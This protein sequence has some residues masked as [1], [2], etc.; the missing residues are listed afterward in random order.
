MAKN[1]EARVALEQATDPEWL[2]R[3][4]KSVAHLADAGAWLQRASSS[5]N[6]FAR[7]RDD[8]Y[9]AAER[10]HAG[11]LDDKVRGQFFA[12]LF[13]K[14]AEP[15]EWAWAQ[16]PQAAYRIS[17]LDSPFRAPTHAAVVTHWREEWFRLV[18]R[19]LAGHDPDPAWL[20][21]WGGHLSWDGIDESAQI[22]AAV[23]DRGGAAG[24]EVFEIL[25]ASAQG[26]HEIGVMGSHVVRAMLSTRRE[27]AWAFIERM[28]LAAQREE[29]L[30]RSILDFAPC[31]HPGALK[32]LLKVVLEENLVRFAST[33]SSL[34]R[35]FGFEWDSMSIGHARSIIERVLG[36]LDDPAAQAAGIKGK[37]AET[38]YLALWCRGHHD[39]PA[40]A[41]QAALLLKEKSAEKAWVGVHALSEFH[42]PESRLV[43]ARAI[44]HPDL[45]VAARAV[46]ALRDWTP[47][48]DLDLAD[49]AA[50]AER[51]LTTFEACERLLRRMGGKTVAIRPI[52][53]PW[54]ETTLLTDDVEGLM[55]S[56]ATTSETS[57]RLIPLLGR[58]SVHTR[59]SA[60]WKIAGREMHPHDAGPTTKPEPL[61]PAVRSTIIGLLKDPAKDVRAAAG[62]L[63]ADEPPTPEELAAHE[64]LMDR[65]A[66]D[67]RT[68]A[69]Q[70]FLKL[71]DD[72]VLEI[73]AR[74]LSGS[75][76]RRLGGL[77]T[78]RSLV[79]SGR[80]VAAARAMAAP[81]RDGSKKP[82]K[83][84]TT[85]L[86][87]IFAAAAEAKVRAD[88]AF[89]LVKDFSPRP[90]APARPRKVELETAAAIGCIL[91]LDDFVEANAAFELKAINWRSETELRPLGSL[92]HA[93]A[94]TPHQTRSA[95][96]DAALCPVASILRPWLAERAGSLRD[97]DG[98]EL[99]RAW[100]LVESGM[101]GQDP[102]PFAQKLKKLAPGGHG[103]K[104]RHPV[105]VHMLLA[106]AMRLDPP[107]GATALLLDGFEDA[108][109]RGDLLRQRE[110]RN[111]FNL[112]T[113]GLSA[114][115]WDRLYHDCPAMWARQSELST[116]ERLSDLV[117]AAASTKHPP[118]PADDDDD[119]DEA[120]GRGGYGS[121]F[122]LGLSEF[123]PLWQAGRLSDD[124]L[125]LRLTDVR[126]QGSDFGA[127]MALRLPGK[128]GR[129]L[130]VALT[131]RLDALLERL[132][133]RVL[134]IELAR[135]IAVTPA[136]PLAVE[137][138][139]S[140]GTEV[141]IPAVV[142]L[143]KR[144]FVRGFIY[145]DQDVA[146]SMSLLVRHAR[147]GPE[148]TPERLAK[149]AAAA[150]LSEQRLV[151]LAV[152]QPRW[153]G[154]VQAA[155]GWPLLEEAVL[156]IRT[157]TKEGADYRL[158]DE[159]EPWEAKAVELT[160]ISAAS[161]AD[162]AVDR[163]W[164]L[165][166][167]KALG[168][169]R[170]GM[171]HDAAKHAS[172][173]NGHIRARLFADA[174]LG[175]ATEKE[176]LARIAAKRHQDAARALGL[177][178]L[179]PGDAGRKQVAARF[180]VLQEMRRTSRKHGGSMLQ[181][182]E[183]RAVEIGMENL[184][185]TA[186]Y[187][188]P[189][190]LQWAMEV[191]EFGDLAKGPV[192]V[193]VG[194]V[195]VSLQVDDEGVASLN[196]VKKGTA[197]KTVPP[198]AK[199]DKKVAALQERLTQLRRQTSRVRQALEQ[200]MC[201]GDAFGGAE[202][203]PL[204]G[205][206]VLR[207]MLAR[208][209]VV[210]QTR[211]GGALAG[212]PDKGGKALRSPTGELEPLRATDTLR[213]AHPLDLLA[214]G[215]WDAWQRECFAAERVQPFKQVF[216]EVY[217]P[218]GPELGGPGA[219]APSMST[220]YA[221]QQVQPRQALALF[222]ARGWVARP[223]EGVQRTFHREDITASVAFEEG[224]YTPAEIDGLTLA[225]V[226][227]S[228]ARARQPV[229]LNEVPP[230]IFSEVYRDLDL[231]VSVA[232]RS[233]VDP[234]ASESTVELRGAL[235]RETCALLSLSNVQVEG[236]RAIIAGTL[237]RYALHL[238]SGTVHSMPG[239]TLW[240]IPVHS[241]HRGRMFLPFADDDPKT[242]EI[243]SKALLL[244]RDAEIRDPA[245][246]AQI[247]AR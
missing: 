103:G 158:E 36:I 72:A 111:G 7:K 217:L 135:G 206:P 11:Q 107:A 133:R 213:I 156:W 22:L 71:S 117:H 200:A 75:P 239:G 110:A 147:P 58:L 195:A 127:L 66:D 20:A 52:V 100:G 181:A 116:L 132:R 201:R 62:V 218:V 65:A 233:G 203:P 126:D 41:E 39:A 226:R 194:E 161:L 33:V 214:T 70:R 64:A 140:G 90:V 49:P 97:A 215:R 152:Y 6:S 94:F 138:D 228:R 240:I 187:P 1:A 167:H 96:E 78:L 17:Y 60:A 178:A 50:A 174:I 212:Y 67:V 139:P 189:L 59:T 101:E 51:D 9:L 47:W 211:S 4:L 221:G 229:P 95:E 98:L 93:D 193:Q 3:R 224:F 42:L 80:A 76:A 247:R 184:A 45:Q 112:T 231:V 115:A 31:G 19:E 24:H 104:L 37:D 44:D 131:P 157:H 124:E 54:D 242:A 227:F 146:S 84:M 123:M 209:V 204:F 122:D 43:V 121:Y 119:D 155:L 223:E 46:K 170:W 12:A 216:R 14:L 125:L 153:A 182:S 225:G 120:E 222:G 165:R 89:G 143:G 26:R 210:G 48:D 238:G 185:W 53:F 32:R 171:L 190:R 148:D 154:H 134:E 235:L 172:T 237:G 83:D 136:T 34:N 145:G 234:E 23:L 179:K 244:A 198:A 91:A 150:G 137:M 245:I 27:D 192:T 99:L 29:G 232:H 142:L 175:H 73:A 13:P 21:T 109:A 88:D 86:D 180:K 246:L 114:W 241:Q 56:A 188:D 186:G 81:L 106:W 162:G 18:C 79:V 159:K 92:R 87:A 69:L 202:I 74:L 219:A 128:G 105:G 173:G 57:G 230:R 38:A 16:R 220:R 35:W 63:L 130:N 177:L 30:R 236:R 149:A 205:H 191:E 176:L 141:L 183:K 118:P 166:C 15:L 25:A 10:F 207:S 196:A 55:V 113:P 61:T 68:R 151:E 28:L 208:L 164:L 108:I 102:K 163:A 40:A 197:L 169:K 77:E 5:M 160:P 82:S 2:P 168:A 144:A 8:T 85:A 129:G 243:L 199:K